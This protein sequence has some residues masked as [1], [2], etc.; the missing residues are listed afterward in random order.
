MTPPNFNPEAVPNPVPDPQA[1]AAAYGDILT[2]NRV[3]TGFG[4]IFKSI[5]TGPAEIASSTSGLGE[6]LQ[7]GVV[8]G[9]MS[10]ELQDVMHGDTFRQAGIKVA[11]LGSYSMS[12]G[13]RATSTELVP[14]IEN[15]S[16]FTEFLGQLR[17]DDVQ[18]GA[19]ETLLDDVIAH[20]SQTVEYCFSPE[21][22]EGLSGEN[23]EQV[24]EEGLNALRTFDAIDGE[25]A[26]LAI[27]G[28]GLRARVE[29]I[30][31]ELSSFLS[32]DQGGVV[33][34]NVRDEYRQHIQDRNK[35]RVYEGLVG[36]IHQVAA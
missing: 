27:D 2:H 20:I 12:N 34:E 9:D 35:L 10:A 4:A 1:I 14:V 25:Y 36:R 29:G 13:E 33:P 7:K 30:S 22:Q 16:L 28:T 23:Q 17:P 8:A 24:L 26:R 31:A 32:A 3:H 11:P 21:G 6:K 5:V 15:T 18:E 19:V